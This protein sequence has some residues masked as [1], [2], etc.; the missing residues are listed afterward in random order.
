M[1]GMD[2]TG[3][4]GLGPRTG[5]ASG[6]RTVG[7]CGGNRFI[8]R[9]RFF[10]RGCGYY[11][12]YGGFRSHLDANSKEALTAQKKLLQEQ[13]SVINRQLERQE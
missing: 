12:G 2:G 13:L 11:H 9:P 8:R 1:P 7:L 5:R 3:P 4:L 10:R 6:Y